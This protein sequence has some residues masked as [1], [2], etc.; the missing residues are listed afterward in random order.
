MAMA[1]AL[2]CLPILFA[3][4]SKDDDQTTTNTQEQPAQQVPAIVS[5][6]YYLNASDDMLQYIDYTVTFDNGIDEILDTV[7]TNRWEKIRAAGL[8]STFTIKTCLRVKEGMYDA[9]AAVDTFYVN[10]GH[11][12]AYQ[13]FDS[14]ATA[15]PGM[16]GIR[17][18]P[19]T[20]VGRGALIAEHVQAGAFDKTYTVS[21]DANGIKIEN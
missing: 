21:F 4:C 20:S 13:I 15:I 8:P 5:M 17:N 16:S 18:I 3:A 7:T 19:S 11:G 1:A 6:M 14:T 9:L 2:M 12:Y 10:R